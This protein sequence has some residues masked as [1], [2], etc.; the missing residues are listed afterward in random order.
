MNAPLELLYQD[1][2]K[3]LN[4]TLHFLDADELSQYHECEACLSRQA[5]ELD[6]LLPQGRLEKYTDLRAE[7]S[8][9]LQQAIFRRGLALGLRL[10]TLTIQ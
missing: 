8:Y 5:K 9:F 2:M 4:S 1:A 7:Q 10:A 3:N 6:S